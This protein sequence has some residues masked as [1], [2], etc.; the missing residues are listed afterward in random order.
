[1]LNRIDV[2]ALYRAGGLVSLFPG[3]EM[4]EGGGVHRLR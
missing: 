4:A 3:S 2:A 1:M